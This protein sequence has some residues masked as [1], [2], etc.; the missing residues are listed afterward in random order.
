MYLKTMVRSPIY[1][2]HDKQRNKQAKQSKKHLDSNPQKEASKSLEF[3]KIT[4]FGEIFKHII[5]L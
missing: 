4:T 3:I 2:R 5:L 1:S